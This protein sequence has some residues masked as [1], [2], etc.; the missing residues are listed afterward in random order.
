VRVR[1]P[2]EERHRVPP[3]VDRVEVLELPA[4][5]G[6]DLRVAVPDRR[7]QPG[8]VTGGGRG[9]PQ[10]LLPEDGEREPVEELVPGETGRDRHG[11]PGRARV[12]QQPVDAAQRQGLRR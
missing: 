3:R 2:G 11:V 7:E 1:Q 9:H 8:R 10:R 5:D 6:R 12:V 4:R